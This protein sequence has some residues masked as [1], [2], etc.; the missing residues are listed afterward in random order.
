MKTWMKIAVMSLFLSAQAAVS[1]GADGTW[2][3]ADGGWQY[4]RPDGGMAMGTW[5][6]IDGEWYHFGND[7]YMQTGWQKVGNIRYFFEDDG[8]LAQG[9]RCYTGDGDEK[10]YYFDRN[11]NAAIRWLNDDGKWYWFNGSGVMNTD[12]AKTIEG[13]KYYF[14]EDGSLK[15]NTYI[16][17]KYLNSEGQPDAAYNV[18]AENSDGKKLTVDDSDKE[19]IAEKLNALPAGWLKKFVDDGWTFIYCPEK[20][21]YSSFKNEDGGDRYYI[22]Y[23]LSTNDRNLRFTDADAIWAGFGEYVYR[24]AKQTLRDY[25]FSWEVGYKTS[26]ICSM[27]E[28]PESLTEDYQAVFG[29]LFSEYLDEN[30]RNDMGEE[31]EDIWR[32]METVI[33]SRGAD[34]K[35]VK[36]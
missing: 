8:T 21:Y 29:A 34:G 2:I 15:A 25:K 6:D 11:G 27:M 28:V 22:R 9:W 12:S 10:W 5:E 24:T 23:K 33:D 32:I 16:G 35:P 31:L 26:E 14:N 1:Y 20:E 3:A 19:E 18:T 13:S 30:S 7:S 17:F 36:E 4:E